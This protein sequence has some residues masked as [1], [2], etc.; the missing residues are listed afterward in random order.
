[1]KILV[2]GSSGHLGESLV[3]TLRDAGHE[4]VGLDVKP[5]PFTTMVGS[6]TDRECLRAC[7]T[8]VRAVYHAATLHKPHVTT[9]GTQAFIDTNIQ[10]TLALLEEAVASRVASFV[11]TSTTSV[12]GDALRPPP[13]KPAAWVTEKVT[14]IPR[15]IY[16]VTKTAAEDLCHL[17]HRTRD[18]DCVILRTSRFFPE[19]DDDKAKRQAYDDGN[20][21]ANEFLFRRV[22]VEDVVS[23]H[24]LAAEM[25][26]SIGFGKYIISATTPFTKEDL[27]EL[28]SNA[29]RALRTR[30]PQYE[31]IYLRL[32]WKMFE[33]ID[34]VYVNE[35]ARNDLGWEPKYDYAHV[36]NCLKE[37]V[38]PRSPLASVIGSKGYHSEVFDEG[39]YPVE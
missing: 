11:F 8:G 38:D 19:E 36:L 3:R 2:T 31:Q 1:M 37:G 28:R 21:K 7:M 14:P 25:A 23:A 22:D 13:G 33:G 20:L 32:G 12:F 6:I 39:P 29:P 5:S 35:A 24:I 30:Y 16:G 17:F 9:H 27:A 10:G 15:N 26:E 18:L 4:V 34:R